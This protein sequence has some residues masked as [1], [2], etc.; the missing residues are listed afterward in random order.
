MLM[1][2]NPIN[3]LAKNGLK[4]DLEKTRNLSHYDKHARHITEK[5]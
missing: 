1:L 3:G 4:G 2:A 5:E